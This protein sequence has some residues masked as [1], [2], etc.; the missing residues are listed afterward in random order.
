MRDRNEARVQEQVHA[1][2]EEMQTEGTPV[3]N[4]T[5][6]HTA[7][8]LL[9]RSPG[10]TV[11]MGKPTCGTSL[12][13]YN[14][15]TVH[16][17]MSS[18]PIDLTDMGDDAFDDWLFNIGDDASG[19]CLSDERLVSLVGTTLRET[20]PEARAHGLIHLANLCCAMADKT[21]GVASARREMPKDSGKY[22]PAPII[23][24]R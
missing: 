3:I 19:D 9:P 22:Q 12:P 20:T 2:V 1:E 11:G 21:L 6:L 7:E 14:L 4:Y 10:V 23:R 5:A 8:R 24:R 17:N 18:V 16:L 15:R 13:L